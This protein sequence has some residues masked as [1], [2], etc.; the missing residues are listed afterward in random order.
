MARPEGEARRP[1]VEEVLGDSSLGSCARREGGGRAS[2][3]NSSLAEEPVPRGARSDLLDKVVTHTLFL[4]PLERVP[5]R[6]DIQY[7]R[8]RLPN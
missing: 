8:T 2:L 6:S 5:S 7:Q 1:A 3:A 4:T